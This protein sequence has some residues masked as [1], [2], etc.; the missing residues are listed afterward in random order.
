MPIN[1]HSKDI[2]TSYT[3]RTADSSWKDLL[4]RHID[5]PSISLAA[6]IGCGGGIYAKALIDLG[7]SEVVGI[8]FSESIL[9]GAREACQNY[10]SIHFNYG[11]ASKTNLEDSSV[12]AI[13]ERALIHHIQDLLPVFQEAHR[14]L[15]NDGV[16]IVQDRTPE[17]CLLTGSEE[18]IRGYFFELFPH[19]GKMEEK[20]RHRSA[21]VIRAMSNAG[22]SKV[23]TIPLWETR[24]VYEKK[25]QLLQ[26]IQTRT[27]RSIL[28]DL[29][30]DQ[31]QSL[32]EHID[33]QLPDGKVTEKDRWTIWLAYK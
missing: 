27:G 33:K 31:L 5:F 7:V 23:E 28:H 1:F 18:H 6:D 11:S 13:L 8:D 25:E 20:R 21:E 16:Y 2:K 4:S 9:E 24:N 30:D 14:V 29:T 10:P 19:L 22:F 15:K 12:E 32:V 26:D 3:T 17:D